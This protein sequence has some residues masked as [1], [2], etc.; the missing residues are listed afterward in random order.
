MRRA[1]Q[2]AIARGTDEQIELNDIEM[3]VEEMLF[4]GGAFNRR[5]LGALSEDN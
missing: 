1:T 4:S 3:A 2:Y 5:I